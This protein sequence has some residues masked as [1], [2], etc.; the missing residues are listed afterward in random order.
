MR[1]LLLV[2]VLTSFTLA[3]SACSGGA[4]SGTGASTGIV[5]AQTAYSNSSVSG[6]YSMSWWNFF[7][8]NQ[9]STY[10]SAVGT[11]QFNGDG[12]ITG[13]TIT[14]YTP[15]TP[16]PC[17][18]SV[19]GTYSIQSTAIGTATLNLSSSTKGCPATDTW[20]LALAA[21]DS[22]AAVEMARTDQIASGSAIKQ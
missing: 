8:N 1:K 13:G 7:A 10:Y 22:G 15:N 20:Q 12:N 9:G 21:A 11:I 6:T 16:Y 18:N 14:E 3:L 17:V 19:T 4:N 5:S 2:C